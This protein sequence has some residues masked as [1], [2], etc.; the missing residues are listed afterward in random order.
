MPARFASRSRTAPS[1]GFAAL[2]PPQSG[3]CEL[4]ALFVESRRMR[5]GVGRTLI[6]DAKRI[7]REQGATRI[8]VL[9]NPQAVA[10]YGRVGFTTSGQAETR[11]GMAP[12]MSLRLEV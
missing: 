5:S 4:D 10:F 3:A 6:D 2:L 8:D 12:C 7:A 9:A 11:F 1:S